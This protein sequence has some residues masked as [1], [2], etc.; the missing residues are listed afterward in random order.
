[1]AA[2]EFGLRGSSFESAGIK[3]ETNGLK[4]CK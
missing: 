4:S 2:S 1:M 3:T